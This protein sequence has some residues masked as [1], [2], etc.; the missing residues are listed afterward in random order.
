LPTL[1]LAAPK[2]APA[3]GGAPSTTATGVGGGATAPA[4]SAAPTDVPPAPPAPPADGTAPPADAPPPAPPADAAPPAAD[5]G[6]RVQWRSE[7]DG[8]APRKHKKK[9]K[10]RHA[11]D[12]E[13]G[14]EDAEGED[15][16]WAP[17]DEEE[18]AG[19]SGGWHAS[20]THFILSAERLTTITGWSATET[21]PNGTF[22]PNTGTTSSGDV[23]TSGTDVS[24]L[25]GGLSRNIYAVPRL[26]FDGRFSNGLTLGG[27]ISYLVQNSKR[28]T[29]SGTN[30]ST[31]SRDAPTAT[32]FVFAPRI[33]V[34]FEASPKVS[35]WLR[36]G[37]TRVSYSLEDDTPTGTS[38]ATTTSTDTTTVLAVTAEPMLVFTPVP[39]I[40]ITLAG[41]L[42]FGASGSEETTT[43]SMSESHDY[44]ASSYGV[45][46]GIAA[47]F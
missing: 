33:G 44:K 1:A 19:E 13:Q 47:L 37:L 2:A 15:D 16:H 27:S 35:V 12:E 31:I 21:L 42:D 10:R 22:N 36:G 30:G 4:T 7:D 6:P 43:G 46:A 18:G 17:V 28:E 40:G 5:G 32:V 25:G 45:N 14:E 8:S 20:Q 29:Q 3:A 39:H 23:D 24:F 34:L 38:G 26:G 9:K 41:T 11:E